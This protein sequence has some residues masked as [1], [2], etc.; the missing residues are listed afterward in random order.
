M[1]RITRHAVPRCDNKQV[2]F[3]S[4][5]AAATMQDVFGENPHCVASIAGDASAL[6]KAANLYKCTHTWVKYAKKAPTAICYQE[7]NG[8]DMGMME[9]PL[10]LEDAS[11][12]ATSGSTVMALLH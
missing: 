11:S 1:A 5:V 4:P 12:M 10:C 7:Q 6:A 3:S 9:S 8:F 2:S